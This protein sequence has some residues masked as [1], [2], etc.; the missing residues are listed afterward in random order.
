M[1]SLSH[2][3]ICGCTFFVFFVGIAGLFIWLSFIFIM[4]I[5]NVLKD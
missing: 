4:G 3:N 5:R 2:M 1:E